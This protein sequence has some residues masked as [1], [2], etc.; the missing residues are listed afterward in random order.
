M[1]MIRIRA[2]KPPPMYIAPSFRTDHTHGLGRQTVVAT[3][4]A[5][6]SFAPGAD[7]CT[8]SAAIDMASPTGSRSSVARGRAR[9]SDAAALG[10]RRNGRR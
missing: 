5:R 2:I 10:G 3:P 4:L 7:A 1:M 9:A 6:N 8:R